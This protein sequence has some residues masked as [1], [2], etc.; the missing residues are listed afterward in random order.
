VILGVFRGGLVEFSGPDI[1]SAIAPAE[2]QET[3][4]PESM[5]AEM[6]DA[7]VKALKLVS[8]FATMDD[9][10]IAGVRSIMS[11]NHFAPGQTI[12]HENEPTG[13]FHVI[14]EGEVEFL[15]SDAQG[16]E[17]VMDTAEIGGFFGELSM[18]TGNPRLVR[19]RATVPVRTLSF[20]REDF[21]DFLLKHPH[22]GID[23]L[24]ALS[25]RL[26]Q[27]DKLLR[28]SVSRNVN[29]VAEETATVG[30]KIADGFAETMGSW[31]FIIVQSTILAV[32]V[33]W[34]AIPGL[35]HWD[36]YPFI[37]LNL[38]L[39][40]QAAYAAPIIM[41]SQNRASN[42]DRISAEIDHQIN[43]KAEI[44]TGL[45]MARLDDLERSMHFLH[46]E[47]VLLLN[48]RNGEPPHVVPNRGTDGPV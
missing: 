15:L 38:A 24:T 7:D 48:K 25:H 26:Y 41:M 30:Q 3:A 27:T 40:F 10:E 14:V 9:R 22:A 6:S 28:Q 23:V 33:V 36:E 29:E 46:Q 16:A 20:N 47:Q 37:F 1:M 4:M 42:K 12:M 11:D 21:H 19:V 34:N 31:A 39:S 32:W 45:I 2:P 44:K 43:I 35:P 5:T 13:A 17:L 18:L 8:L